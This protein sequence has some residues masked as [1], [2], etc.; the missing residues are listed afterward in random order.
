MPPKKSEDGATELFEHE[1]KDIYD[2]EK[3]L[4]RATQS[5]SKKVKD[6]ELSA[7]L[8]EH[9]E[10]TE[11]QVGRLEEVFGLMGKKP[12]R[13]PCKGINGLIEEFTTFVKEEKP[14]PEVL[15]FFATGAASKV[16]F[17]EIESYKGLIKL[18]QQMGQDEA[19]RLLGQNLSEEE[20]TA[21]QLEVMGEKLLKEL[22]AV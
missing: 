8:L 15:N 7:A 21:D 3:K 9:S 20:Q 2:A 1:L 14:S 5:M 10:V 12:S 17:Y 6:R 16:E 11:V 22:V 4:V 19:A 13:E 18:A